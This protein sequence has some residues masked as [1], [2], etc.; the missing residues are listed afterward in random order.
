MCECLGVGGLVLVGQVWVCGLV[1]WAGGRLDADSSRIRFGCVGRC[2]IGR[3]AGGL[4]AGV[5][6]PKVTVSEGI[7]SKA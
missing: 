4:D 3:R 7:R 5:R 1:V 6:N 2:T